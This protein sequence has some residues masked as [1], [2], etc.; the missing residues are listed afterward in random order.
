MPGA[1]L[2]ILQP[3]NPEG[4][5]IASGAGGSSADLSPSPGPGPGAS[6]KCSSHRVHGTEK[7][8]NPPSP[9]E[10][11]EKLCNS[12]CRPAVAWGGVAGG[13]VTASWP[14]RAVSERFCTG[15]RSAIGAAWGA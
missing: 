13:G 5:G 2:V 15:G 3:V 7:R 4:W 10:Q 12:G 8:K 9:Q 6:T 14:S 11:H 1:F